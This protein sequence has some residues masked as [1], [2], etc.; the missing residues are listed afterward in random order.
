MNTCCCSSSNPLRSCSKNT[1]ASMGKKNNKLGKFCVLV[2]LLLKMSEEFVL[3]FRDL[4]QPTN[5]KRIV[6]IF[7]FLLLFFFSFLLFS[8]DKKKQGVSVKKSEAVNNK[9]LQIKHQKKR[10]TLFQET[11]KKKSC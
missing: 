10:K 7:F 1:F 4:H 8:H 5:S 6:R 11:K 3:L 2:P 9:G